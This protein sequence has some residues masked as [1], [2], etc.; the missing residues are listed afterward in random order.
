MDL[1]EQRIFPPIY[2]P[3]LLTFN[4]LLTKWLIKIGVTA[5]SINGNLFTFNSAAAKSS[6][7]YNCYEFL[8]YYLIYVHI[9][10]Y[11]DW[12]LFKFMNYF[13]CFAR[14]MIIEISKSNKIF[15][16]TIP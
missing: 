1:E 6:S 2:S 16:G 8:L 9:F 7:L 4:K 11:I 3:K 10:L 15:A 14:K 13:T 5:K 12:L